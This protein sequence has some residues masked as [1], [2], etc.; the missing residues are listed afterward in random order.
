FGRLFHRPARRRGPL[1]RR[2]A[3]APGDAAH[4]RPAREALPLAGARVSRGA[5]VRSVPSWRPRLLSVD[6]PGGLPAP[7]AG[8]ARARPPAPARRLR[9]RAVP[10]HVRALRAL[11]WGA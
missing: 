9:G 10:H 5:P 4:A 7:H 1:R 6:G 8:A 2:R 3:P 11:T